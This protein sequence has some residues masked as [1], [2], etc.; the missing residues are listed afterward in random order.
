MS[1]VPRRLVVN[2][3]MRQITAFVVEFQRDEPKVG[4][5]REWEQGIFV[6]RHDADDAGVIYDMDGRRV[7]GPIW[8]YRDRFYKGCL[9]L[10]EDN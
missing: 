7:K 2:N 4:S 9:V 1:T 8:N 3:H 6:G 5:S 10:K